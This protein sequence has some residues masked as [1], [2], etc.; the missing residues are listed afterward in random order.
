IVEFRWHGDGDVSISTRITQINSHRAYGYNWNASTAIGVSNP[1]NNLKFEVISSDEVIHDDHGGGSFWPPFS[2]NSAM[3]DQNLYRQ[4][5]IGKAGIIDKIY[6]MRNDNN[7]GSYE[8]FTVFLV[9]SNV[10][11]LSTFF[12]SNYGSGT[13]VEVLHNVTRFFSG[14]AGE[15]FEI[16]VDDIFYYNNQDNLLV[17][18]RWEYTNAT[19]N[20]RTKYRSTSL[21]GDYYGTVFATNDYYATTGGNEK[22]MNIMKFKFKDTDLRWDITNV[23]PSLMT[24]NPSDVTPG[25]D[26]FTITPVPDAFGLDLVKVTLTDNLQGWTASQWVDVE[27]LPVNDPPTTPINVSPGDKTPKRWFAGPIPIQWEHQDIDSPQQ[28][29]SIEYKLGSS[30]TWDKL[31]SSTDFPFPYPASDFLWLNPDRHDNIYIRISTWDGEYWSPWNETPYPFAFDDVT[32]IIESV[33]IIDLAKNN[34]EYVRNGHVVLVSAK[35]AAKFFADLLP[36]SYIFA[37]LTGFSLG[38]KEPIT[39]EVNNEY[40]NITTPTPVITIPENGIVPVPVFIP[41]LFGEPIIFEA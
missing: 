22:N 14:K 24:I 1:R 36:G 20:I 32:P 35:L 12:N 6:F 40:A 10:T 5:M 27:V 3:R 39:I 34:H 13:P 7:Y 38:D 26:R 28:N 16:D 15:W 31:F 2:T 19:S 4:S 30:G 33:E 29:V 11:S 41:T 9:N 18:I 17:E 23:D 21:Y 25:D 37:N 8:N